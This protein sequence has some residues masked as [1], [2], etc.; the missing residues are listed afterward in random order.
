MTGTAVATADK[1]SPPVPPQPF[2][3][4][5]FETS[6]PDQDISL[7]QTAAV[8]KFAT[9]QIS[10]NGWLSGI[11][12]YFQMTVTGQATNNVSYSKDN[13]FSVIDKVTVK[14]VGNR[15]IFG[16]MS[17]Y[18][19][20]TVN[21]WGGYFGSVLGSDPRAPG[22]VYSATTGTGSTAGSFAFTLWIPFEVE[23][24]D[25]LGELEN[26]STSSSYTL[27]IYMATQASTYNQ[28]PSVMGTLRMR[29]NLDGYTEPEI[30]DSRGRPYS[31]QP[32][33][34]GTIQYWTSEI[35]QSLAAGTQRY[36]IV[37]GIGY[38]IRGL[39]YLGYAAADNTR[40]TTGLLGGNL[41]DPWTQSFGKVQLWQLPIGS[42]LSK[43]Q[44]WYELSNSTVDT[45]GGPENGVLAW[46]FFRDFT[47]QVGGELRN[48]YLITKAGNVL[49]FSGSFG[50]STTMH[51]L[52]NYVV[53]P[54]NDAARLRAR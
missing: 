16:P 28:V 31:Q 45:Y 44:K 9:V 4:G 47:P 37:N 18:E 32:P 42:W 34:A 24:R 49:Q 26:K 13:P 5:T 54:G 38:P 51:I 8:Q 20:F 15:E 41:P 17:G 50:A 6:T 2:R 35:P 3:V 36:N 7:A 48:G 11:F 52:V 22:G 46:P 29:A 10:P 53:P 43:M 21:K 14:D 12:C 33:A 40:A 25:T 1:N 27:E 19:W 30:G 23:R 39:I